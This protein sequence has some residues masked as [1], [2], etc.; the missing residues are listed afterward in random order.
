MKIWFFAKLPLHPNPPPSLV[1][2]IS[3]LDFQNS[4]M[5]EEE[6]MTEK[7]RGGWASK[8]D[9]VLSGTQI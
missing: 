6:I 4:A 3:D 1:F 2:F 7:G 9:F 8:K 5:L